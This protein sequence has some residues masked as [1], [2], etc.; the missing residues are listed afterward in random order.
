MDV[1]NDLTPG[2]IEEQSNEFCEKNWND[3]LTQY[4]DKEQPDRLE[5]QCFKAAWVMAV[6]KYGLNLKDDETSP[7]T[8]DQPVVQDPQKPIFQPADEIK[9]ISVS[10]T[11]GATLLHSIQA[12]RDKILAKRRALGK[13]TNTS[14]WTF[15]QSVA[16]FILG[17]TVA[18]GLTIVFIQWIKRRRSRY[19][20]VQA[21][22]RQRQNAFRSINTNTNT[23][24]DVEAARGPSLS[25]SPLGMKSITTLRSSTPP[26]PYSSAI[27]QHSSNTGSSNRF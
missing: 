11:L 22:L 15:S 14:D 20:G 3:I 16:V 2:E 25:I 23:I 19:G 17:L 7:K 24:H 10:W 18:G 21:W 8:P 9:G 6:L 12:F 27:R 4:K 1:G 5:S 26:I 13:L